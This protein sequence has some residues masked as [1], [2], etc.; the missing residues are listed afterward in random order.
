[1][2]EPW[3]ISG[4]AF[5]AW[6]SALIVG[7]LLLNGVWA[8]RQRRAGDHGAQAGALIP[9]PYHLAFLVSGAR[10]ATETA[11]A[12]LL[13]DGR[14]RIASTGLVSRTSGGATSDA[15]ENAVLDK[16]NTVRA[17]TVVERATSSAACDAIADDLAD[18]GLLVPAA[19]VR[20]RLR[21]VSTLFLVV[22]AVGVLRLVDGVSAARPVGFLIPLVVI[23]GIA[24]LVARKASARA[25]AGKRTVLGDRVAAEARN[26]HD[27]NADEPD[28]VGV[29]TFGFA[30]GAVLFGGLAVYPDAQIQDAL[31]YTPPPVSGSGG[32]DSGGSGGDSGSSCSG[33]GGGCGGGG[34]GGCGG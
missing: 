27:H 11:L 15:L 32:A 9:P 3:G 31:T 4:P 33:S 24:A 25:R 28:L 29:S 12:T 8:R 22:G 19:V 20:S 1:M 26:R 7:V 14:L 17:R 30:A 21:W 6:Y 5:L 18:R 10:R 2:T 23:A 34:C 16:A 13:A